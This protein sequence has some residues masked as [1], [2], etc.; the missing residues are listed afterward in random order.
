M[1]IVKLF[2]VCEKRMYLRTVQR[3]HFTF[4]IPKKLNEVARV[5]LLRQE[6]P[7]KIRQLWLEQFKDRKD[8]VVGT[9]A[10]DEYAT[11]K[12]NATACPMFLLP[13]LKSGGAAYF[14]L[15][16]QYQDGK[17]CLLTSLDAFKLN[18]AAAPPMMVSTIYDDLVHEKGI[19]LVRG[20]IINRLEI[21]AEEARRILKFM[22][23]FYV[24]KFDLVKRF[25]LEPR[26]FD[27]EGFLNQSKQFYATV[28]PR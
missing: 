3:T 24:N 9:M 2:F 13:V 10:A 1:L 15:V 27:Y 28:A 8:V 12:A 14:N 6:S 18:P 22:R 7:V 19:A 4:P 23:Y 11:F 17:H 21:S 26:E 25:N 20:D 5:A 16:S